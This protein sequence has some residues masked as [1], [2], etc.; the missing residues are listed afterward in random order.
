MGKG[1]T[2]LGQP[3]HPTA[4]LSPTLNL[5]IEALSDRSTGR[6]AFKRL[7]EPIQEALAEAKRVYETSLLSASW[8]EVSG[9]I[10]PPGQSFT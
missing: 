7:V 5:E 8:S 1:A 3:D 10:I 9:E 4:R 6:A 2:S